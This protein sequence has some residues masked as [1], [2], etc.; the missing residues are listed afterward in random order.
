M[1]AVTITPEG[2]VLLDS[3]VRVLKAGEYGAIVEAENLI[4]ETRRRKEEILENAGKAAEELRREGYEAGLLEGKNEVAEQFFEA[5]SA[6]VEQ[7]ASMEK[8]LVEVVVQSLRAILGSFDREELAEQV[9]G[10]AL[11]LVR[12]EKKVLLRVAPDDAAM[13]EE[14]LDGILRKYPGIVR[15]DVKPDPALTS[16]GCVMETELGVI[17]ATLERQLAI[18]EDA[19]RRQLEG[20][21]A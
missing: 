21:K 3:G 4:A 5:V 15:V 10:H 13:V 9:V 20:G 18:I 11:R 12:D 16:G 17:D 19:F 2:G 1:A 7:V 8:S 6:S 14:R